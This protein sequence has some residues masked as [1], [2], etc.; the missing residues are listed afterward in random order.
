MLRKTITV[1][2]FLTLI[3][4]TPS[5]AKADVTPLTAE[6]CKTVKVMARQILI[7]M[8]QGATQ[9]QV[10]QDL[11]HRSMMDFGK[12]GEIVKLYLQVNTSAFAR[13]IKKGFRVGQILQIVDKD[14]N[15]QVE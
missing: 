1:L 6:H 10:M 11:N 5:Y 3:S 12:G 2:G 13:N 7:A 9:Y 15:T 8:Q 14:C 4:C